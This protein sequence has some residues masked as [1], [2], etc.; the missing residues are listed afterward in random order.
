MSG[1]QV[2]VLDLIGM[3]MRGTDFKAV[4]RALIMARQGGAVVYPAEMEKA[5]VQGVDLEKITLAF[6]QAKKGTM[7]VTFQEI[8]DAELDDRLARLLD[9]GR[10]APQEE[11]AYR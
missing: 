11:L 5:W 8:V 4:V 2:R 10:E 6:I 7:D 3:R 1:A 9:E